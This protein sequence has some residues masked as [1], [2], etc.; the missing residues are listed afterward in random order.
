MQNR[1]VSSAYSINSKLFVAFGILSIYIRNNS[2]PKID[3]WGTPVIRGDK[4]EVV[5][6]ISTY[7][8]CP[9]T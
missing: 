7:C 1:L 9:V 3:P 8:F 4:H 2:G 6:S 5:L